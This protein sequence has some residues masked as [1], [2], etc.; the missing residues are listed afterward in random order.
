MSRESHESLLTIG[1][2][3]YRRTAWDLL[4]EWRGPHQ[5]ATIL[6]LAWSMRGSAGVAALQG[7]LAAR[8]SVGTAVPHLWGR[9]VTR[10]QL[11][12]VRDR[13]RTSNTRASGV[14]L[15]RCSWIFWSS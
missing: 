2:D 11:C 13:L 7:M 3:E 12:R 1:T 5:T 14:G 4:G 6:S 10:R 15:S 8:I 9:P